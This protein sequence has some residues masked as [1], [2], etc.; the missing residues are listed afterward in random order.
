M[1]L[2]VPHGQRGST[3]SYQSLRRGPGKGGSQPSSMTTTNPIATV[4]GHGKPKMLA[5]Y[6]DLKVFL[7]GC[8]KGPCSGSS[9][10]LTSIRWR[11]A[12]A[13]PERQ[14]QVYACL[15][16]TLTKPKVPRKVL[17]EAF[18]NSTQSPRALKYR[19]RSF[20]LVRL[21]QKIHTTGHIVPSY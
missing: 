2:G 20:A 12:A 5:L 11:F 16:W 13:R 3:I 9:P 8:F 21:L 17:I 4:L 1:V 6:I 14:D 10:C 19:F 15:F 7:S 18:C